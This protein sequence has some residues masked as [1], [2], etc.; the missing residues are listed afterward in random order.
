MP[1][2]PDH[3]ET[4]REPIAFFCRAKPQGADAFQ[5]CKDEG[6]IFIGYPLVR[7]GER[8]DP[9]AL[10]KCL[11]DPT[12][13]D[14]EWAREMK[15]QKNTRSFNRNRNFIKLVTPGSIVVIPRPERG[16]VYIGSIVSQFEIDDSPPWAGAYLKLRE[17]QRVSLED[18]THLHIADVAQGWQVDRYKRVDLSRLPGW[19]RHSMFGRSTFGEF[20]DHPLGQDTATAHD[21]LARVLNGQSIIRA[22]WTLEL[23]EI[24]CRLVDSLTP[25]AFEHLVVSLL[26]LENPHEIW[27]QTGGPGDGGIDGL[28]SNENGEVVG[29]MQ[30]KLSAGSSPELGELGHTVHEIKRYAAVLVPENPTPP[31]DGTTLL[32]LAWIAD[33][34]RRHWRALPQARSMRVGEGHG[35]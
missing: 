32:D 22:F 12:C 30:A 28:G 17:E 5:V 7:N 31:T 35:V 1:S 15:K 3:P 34:V 25:S 21:M 24:K 14:E 6:R 9:K 18:K 10:R 29:I 23:N 2:E 8:Y 13:P 20:K 11:V 27:Q 26:Q 4:S 16:A 19:L 33:A